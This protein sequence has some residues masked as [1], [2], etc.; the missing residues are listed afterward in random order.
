MWWIIS[1]I[2]LVAL[3][4]GV[5]KFIDY[6]KA[7]SRVRPKYIDVLSK[8][9][10]ER[11]SKLKKRNGYTDNFPQISKEYRKLMGYRCEHCGIIL[12]GKRSFYLH[13]HHIDGNKK[14][15][16]HS[17]FRALC[18]KCHS[19]QPGKGHRRLIDSKDYK[20]FVIKFGT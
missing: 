9:K 20:D 16:L 7:K 13:T 1:L 5:A 10:K 15:N 12:K 19:V 17:N 18:I 6:S 2:L 14:N 8:I 11:K 3:F 4:I